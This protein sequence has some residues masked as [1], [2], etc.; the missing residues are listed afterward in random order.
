MMALLMDLDSLVQMMSI[1]TLMAYSMVAL[2]VLVLHYQ[3]DNVGYSAADILDE[4]SMVRD[5]SELSEGTIQ[6]SV[7]LIFIFFMHLYFE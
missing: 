3:R 7:Y 5:S 2:S 6:A 4:I 1:G